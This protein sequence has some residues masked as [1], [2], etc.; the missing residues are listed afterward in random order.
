VPGKAF[1]DYGH[2]SKLILEMPIQSWNS[3]LEKK[4]SLT[5]SGIKA[6]ETNKPKNYTN[7]L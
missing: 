3:K 5:Q 4:N 7:Q 2:L 1:F 6:K